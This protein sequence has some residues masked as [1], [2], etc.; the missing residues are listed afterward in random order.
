ML[1]LTEDRYPV[2]VFKLFSRLIRFYRSHFGLFWLVMIPVIIFGLII[3]LV[4]FF[5]F[6][7]LFPYPSWDFSISDG[8]TATSEFSWNI[9][10][11]F[12]SF[13]LIFLWFALSM[14][15]LLSSYLFRGTNVSFQDIWQQ[16]YRRKGT[17][18]GAGFILAV[19]CFAIVFIWLFLNGLLGLV[20]NYYSLMMLNILGFFVVL[21]YFFV[22]WSLI[23]QGIMIEDLTAVRAFRRSSEL[24]RGNWFRFFGKYLLLAWITAVLS[25]ILMVI[26][27]LLLS[28]AAP[29]LLPIRDKLVSV[30]FF[31]LLFGIP[32]FFTYM[33]FSFSLGNI[34]LDLSFTPRFWI[35]FIV[36]LVNTLTYAVMVQLWGILTTHLYYEQVRRENDNGEIS[37]NPIA[38]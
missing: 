26:T 27:L 3:D 21:I 4:M 36:L 7:N 9:T 22:R 5:C 32:F 20:V 38:V 14:F 35:T 15:V 16:T 2:G 10:F 8:F 29:E 12:S 33:G 37:E 25:N 13:L 19:W 11:T 31:T 18:F 1:G 24:V 28:F 34:T 30:E 17:I 6:Y 23:H